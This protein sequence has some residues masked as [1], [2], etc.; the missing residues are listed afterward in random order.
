M[1]QEQTE[2]AEKHVKRKDEQIESLQAQ[3][4]RLKEQSLDHKGK[5]QEEVLKEQRNWESLANSK[6]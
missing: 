2:K 6:A 1:Y 4:D 5:V 3:I